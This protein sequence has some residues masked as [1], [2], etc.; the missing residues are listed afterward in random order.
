MYSL[1]TIFWENFGACFGIDP[2]VCIK[3][4][5]WLVDRGHDDFES[6]FV[7]SLDLLDMTYKELTLPIYLDNNVDDG[8][9]SWRLGILRGTLSVSCHYRVQTGVWVMK[10]DGWSKVAS[11]SSVSVP[12]H[13]IEVFK[14]DKRIWPISMQQCF[15]D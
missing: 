13:D 8:E 7:A 4:L 2:A 6:W 1:R 9:V 10:E 12:Y 15:Q 14:N 3:K 5:H 11:V